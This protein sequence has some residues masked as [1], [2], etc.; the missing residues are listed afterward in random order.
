MPEHG[1]GLRGY[2]ICTAP[3]SGSN[4]LCELLSRTGVLGRPL[5]YLNGFARRQLDD[6]CY[7]DDPREQVARILTMGRTLNGVYGLKMFASQFKQVAGSIKLSR[8]LPDLR[9]IFLR[10]QDVLGQAI[11]WVRGLQNNQWRST[12]KPVGTISYDGPM[13]DAQPLT[14]V[15]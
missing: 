13:I 1:L 2:V 10:R 11:S 3:R 5:E 8:D 9:F 15:E 12:Q 7:P 6:P 14:I 4:W